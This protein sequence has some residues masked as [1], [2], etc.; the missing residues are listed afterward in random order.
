MFA[1]LAQNGNKYLKTFLVWRSHHIKNKPFVL[2][3]SVVIG[4]FCAVAAYLLKQGVH[5]VET[6]FV[7]TVI[8]DNS[9]TL[10]FL[11]PFLGIAITRLL[12]RYVIK[13][14][15][16]PGIPNA[17]YALSKGNG[18]ISI[19]KTFSSVITAAFTVGFGG[20]CGLEGPAVGTTSAI[21]SN[22]SKTL[23]LNQKTRKLMIGCGAAAALSAIFKA[24]V[25]A[26]VFAMEVI[27]LDITTFSLIPLLLSSVTAAL[28]SRLFFGDDLLFQFPIHEKIELAVVPYYVAL[29]LIGGMVGVYFTKV[30]FLVSNFFGRIK[31]TTLKVL[32]GGAAIGLLL[33][34]FP[35]LYGEGYTTVYQLMNGEE[36]KVL[37]YSQLQGVTENIWAVLV[38]LVLVIVFKAFAT[39]ITYG[40]GG[41]GGIF[42]PTLFMGSIMGFVFSKTIN[43]L[44]IGKLSESNF[45]LVG[46]AALMAGILQAPLTAIFLI[47]EI[48]GGYELFIPLMLA[49][50]IAFITVKYFSEHSVY[51]L[52]LAKKGQLITHDK[53]K[54]VLTLMDLK[55]E[56]ETNF[57]VIGPYNTLGDLVKR[58]TESTRNLFP[59]VDEHNRF[60]GVVTLDD[61]RKIMFDNY[62]Y[63][64]T[65]VHELMTMAPEHI[66]ITDSME[67]VM[68]KFES[69]GAWNLPVVNQGKYLGFVSKSRLYSEYRKRLKDFYEEID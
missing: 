36:T 35:P 38:F 22:L 17:L 20:S 46:M 49:T 63:E 8:A 5:L 57:K 59:V 30:H 15:A 44:G 43:L 32:I 60:L 24:P 64:R 45:S 50:S 40:A 69:S 54:A 14:E 12:I 65:H 51:T 21:G 67:R 31:R 61:I 16:E 11:L 39:T 23:R 4:F 3:L 68:E 19:K 10:Y 47:A 13:E 42:A 56:I 34:L 28:F 2:V 33:F 27:L 48:T 37:E 18:L 6:F 66:E 25:A 52:Q 62:M 7:D 9:Q 29:G 1:Q 53:D 58:V 26:I 41:V 55:N